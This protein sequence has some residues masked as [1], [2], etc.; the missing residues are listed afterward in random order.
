MEGA[1]GE[2]QLLE[3]HQVS[4]GAP[5]FQMCVSVPLHLLSMPYACSDLGK[6]TESYGFL[7]DEYSIRPSH[8]SLTY[9]QSLEQS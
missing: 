4:G 8:P 7:T 3:C 5:A 6:G 1:Y 2:I 9:R